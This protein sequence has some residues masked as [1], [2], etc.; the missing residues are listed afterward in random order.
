MSFLE[1]PRPVGHRAYRIDDAA[2]DRAPEGHVCDANEFRGAAE[3]DPFLA[4]AAVDGDLMRASEATNER[5]RPEVASRSLD[6]RSVERS[7]DVLIVADAREYTNGFD[8]LCDV[9]TRL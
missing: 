4:F 8:D 1:Y 6:V 5:A 2:V 3:W 7:S 9:C